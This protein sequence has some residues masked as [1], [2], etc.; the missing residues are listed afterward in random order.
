MNARDLVWASRSELEAFCKSKAVVRPD[1]IATC[2]G[3]CFY[4][5]TLSDDPDVS[6]WLREAGCWEAWVTMATGRLVE[7]RGIK[8]AV[9]IGAN[10]GYYALFLSSLGVN[11]DAF[12]PSPVPFQCI[13]DSLTATAQMLDWG[14]HIVDASQYN[15]VAPSKGFGQVTTIPSA[16]AVASG[17]VSLA[18]PPPS[19][20]G[21][22]YGSATTAGTPDGWEPMVVPAVGLCDLHA[23]DLVF[24]DAEGAE[25]S[26]FSG[27]ES[28]RWLQRHK[29]A[30]VCEW[31]P[32]RYKDPEASIRFW[33][34]M[35]WKISLIGYDGDWK[36][37][38][39][40]ELLGAKDWITILCEAP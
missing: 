11:V 25:E 32:S 7:R 23:T 38:S 39:K 33:T 10:I 4:I 37:A 17:S 13:L 36:R 15:A 26:I 9:N 35:G 40:A 28:Q 27:E 19:E 12:E 1:N 8:R 30:V 18:I 24:C 5:A 21:R 3:G 34:E 29:P 31:S 16:V 20:A 2:L 22:Q 6:P 14:A